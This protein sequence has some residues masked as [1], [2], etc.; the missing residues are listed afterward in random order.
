MQKKVKPFNLSLI[1]KSLIS[2]SLFY[3]LVFLL[4]CQSPTSPEKEE[5]P[6]HITGVVTERDTGA[7]VANIS[8]MLGDTLGRTNNTVSKT[9]NEGQYTILRYGPCNYPVESLY[10][11]LNVFVDGRSAGYIHSQSENPD[12]SSVPIECTRETQTINFAVW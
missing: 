9:N 6:I 12:F 10:L 4:A 7:A 2:I 1:L 8:V 3:I 5:L 11:R